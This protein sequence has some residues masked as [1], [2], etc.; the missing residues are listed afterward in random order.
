MWETQLNFTYNDYSLDC[1]RSRVLFEKVS[2]LHNNLKPEASLEMQETQ[3]QSKSEKWFSERWCSLTASKCLSAF[4][5]GKLV[6]ESLTN[7]AVEGRKFIL[8]KIWDLVLKTFR[9]TGC[10]MVLNVNQRQS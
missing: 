4:Q 8:T 5:I 6:Y 2:A 1:E 10:V 9:L 7:A 3:E